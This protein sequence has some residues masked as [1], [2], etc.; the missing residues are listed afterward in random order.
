MEAIFYKMLDDNQLKRS[1]N[2]LEM[3]HKAKQAVTIKELEGKL[4]ISKK[5]VFS[6]LEY[7]KT[8]LPPT[9]SVTV[10]DKDVWIQHYDT[11]QTIEGYIIEIA[12]STIQYR[13][14]KH[15]FYNG[16]MSIRDLAEHLYISESSLRLRIKHM[17]K[18]LSL[19]RLSISFYDVQLIGDE[20]NIR[21]FFYAYFSEFQE[22]FIAACEPKLQH[23]TN[24]YS[25]MREMM[26]PFDDKPLHFSYQQIIRWLF[27]IRDRM[28]LGNFV[29]VNTA[30]AKRIKARASYDVFKRIYE[31]EMGRDLAAA[32]PESEIIWAYIVQY[33]SIVYSDNQSMKLFQDDPDI[34]S[35]KRKS[36]GFLRGV[37]AKMKICDSDKE[38]FIAIHTA[39]LINLSLLEEVLPIFQQGY[40]PV[41]KRVLENL[42]PQYLVWE[43]CLKCLRKEEISFMSNTR[44]MAAQL[45]MISSQ[46][47]Y[48]QENQAERILYSFEGEAG[49]STYLEA[50]AKTL[51]PKGVEGVFIYDEPIN[52]AA[53]QRIK[54]DVFVCNYKLQEEAI[55][56]KVLRM[57]HEPLMH[58]W[59]FLK[60]LI[61]NKDASA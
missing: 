55:G 41:Q 26:L 61:I 56:C 34:V 8:L 47:F 16:K 14:L 57:S 46:F 31:T 60:E 33:N 38:R 40:D 23:F 36:V 45:A 58:E 19:F 48:T 24:L 29:R 49:F 15:V 51:L 2:I 20:T 59:T 22:L 54:P 13:V 44:S 10:T 12:K 39:F 17:N 37:A 43:K 6:T 42:E 5:T 50:M 11:A 53:I 3:L 21:Y 35:L 52:S 30:L 32:M 9:I 18:V 27:I 7:I 1:M 28:E 4:K 25:K